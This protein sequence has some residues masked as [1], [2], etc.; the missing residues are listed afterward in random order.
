MM[1]GVFASL[2]PARRRLVLSLLAVLCIAILVGAGI[3]VARAVTGSAASTTPA[4]QRQPGPVLLVPGYG[5]SVTAL[6]A[7]ASK[8]TS[9]G[10]HAEVVPLPGDG[11][12]DLRAQAQALATAAKAAAARYDASSVDVVGYSAGGVVA[13]LWA[14]DYGGNQLARRIVTLG[15]PQHG[16]ELASLGSELSI[17]CPI[18]CQQLT[19]SS[20]LLAG[21]NAKPEPTAGPQY[22]SIWTTKDEVVV[23]PDSARLDGALNL[24]VQSVCASSTVQH[25]NLPTDPVIQAMVL[26][27]LGAGS[28]VPLTSADCA[29]LSS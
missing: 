11:T 17:A 8:L 25:G 24:T 22:V 4:A 3:T 27:E 2:A 16:T 15:S 6:Q 10:K 7:L 20:S 5:G 26:S 12:G 13:R 21:L 29:R 19:V 9:A 14:Q 1:E 23:P 18:A 28:P